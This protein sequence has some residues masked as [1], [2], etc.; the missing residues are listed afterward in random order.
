MKH[1]ATQRTLKVA[2]VISGLRMRAVA[3]RSKFLDF[4]I[5]HYMPLV[6]VQANRE[7]IAIDDGQKSRIRQAMNGNV[8]TSDAE[9]VALVE[10]AIVAQQKTA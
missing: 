1:K 3:A 8:R 6:E 10:R 2:Q 4:G 9:L 5:I 7:G